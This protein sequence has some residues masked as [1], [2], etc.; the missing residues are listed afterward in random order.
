MRRFTFPVQSTS[1]FERAVAAFVILIAIFVVVGIGVAIT[2]GGLDNLGG[3]GRRC[4]G[5]SLVFEDYQGNAVAVQPNSPE[6]GYV[7]VP[8]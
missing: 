2:N 4:Q 3:D 7:S 6:C 1:W 8:R 5:T